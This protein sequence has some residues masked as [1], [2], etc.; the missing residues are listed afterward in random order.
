MENVEVGQDLDS[1]MEHISYENKVVWFHNLGFDGS[2]I[3]DWLFVNGFSHTLYDVLVAGEFKTIID[4]FTK[5]YSITVMFSTGFTVEFRD[6]YK[7]LAMSVRKVAETYGLDISKGDIDYHAFRPIGYM[8]SEEE[9]D[10]LRRDVSI[11]GQAMKIL[12][13]NGMTRLTAPGDA[14]A[15]YKDLEGMSQF[16][17]YFPILDLATDSFIREAYRGGF[18]YCS[19]QYQQKF[20]GSGLVLDVNSMYPYVMRTQLLP[21]GHPEWIRDTPEP[22]EQYPLVINYYTISGKLKPGHI[23]CVQLTVSAGGGSFRMPEY[24]EEFTCEEM[25]LTNIDLALIQDHYDTEII[26]YNGGYRFKATHGMFDEFID[27]W[28]GIK[29]TSTGG[30]RALAKLQLNSLYGK[31]G[32]NPNI[33]PKIPYYEDGRVHFKEGPKET[34]DPIY[35]AMA[36]FITSYA[37]NIIIREAQRNYDVF[38]YCDTDS[39]HLICDT[40]PPSIDVDPVRLGAWKKEYN[41]IQGFFVRAKCYMEQVSEINEHDDDCNEGCNWKHNF[42]T[43]IAGLNG[44][45]AAQLD[46]DALYDGNVIDGKLASKR[47]A[48]GVILEE[49]TFTIKM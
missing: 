39:L 47:V 15:E 4:R 12:L 25:A 5:M 32:T 41:F 7:K 30:M 35:T 44:F 43:A 20:T 14:L 34:R 22:S 27:K 33:T 23:P 8:P 36:V 46:F 1:F 37:R 11:V 29:Q 45:I 9:W 24:V 17:Q 16:N 26:C 10:Y 3:L 31:F 18:T 40:V 13:D 42:H 28:M 49:T 2:F 19:P 6:S 48:G 21:Y 38:A